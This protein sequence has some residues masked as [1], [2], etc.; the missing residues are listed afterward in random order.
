MKVEITVRD[1]RNGH[2]VDSDGKGTV[3][4]RV[5]RDAPLDEGDV[6]ALA[7]GARVYVIG[8]EEKIGSESYTQT[9][10]VDSI[11]A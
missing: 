8:S 9:V 4:A 6:I 3:L 1:G 10:Y 11:P 5:D 7:D 2:E